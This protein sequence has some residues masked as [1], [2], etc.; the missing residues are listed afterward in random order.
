MSDSRLVPPGV[1]SEIAREVRDIFRAAVAETERM[2]ARMD[3]L[4]RLY[5]RRNSPPPSGATALHAVKTPP[6]KQQP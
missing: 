1:A 5:G 4:G 3:E 6:A 2:S